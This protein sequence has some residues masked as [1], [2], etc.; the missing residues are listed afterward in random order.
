ML[1]ERGEQRRVRSGSERLAFLVAGATGLAATFAGLVLVS[2]FLAFL[3]AVLARIGGHT[4]KLHQILG[5][6]IREILQGAAKRKH[7][8]NALCIGGQFL[9]TAGQQIEAMIE[10]SLPGPNTRPRCA[11]EDL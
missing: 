4:R 6:L 3:F 11:G 5:V 9:V 7:L 8:R 2:V 1:R 10:A